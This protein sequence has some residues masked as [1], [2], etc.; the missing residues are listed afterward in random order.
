MESLW[1][2]EAGCGLW[3]GEAATCQRALWREGLSLLA[4][5]KPSRK[6]FAAYRMTDAISTA[7]RA[8]VGAGGGVFGGVIVEKQREPEV[9]AVLM[10][11][12][13]EHFVRPSRVNRRD[14]VH[15]T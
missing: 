3:T 14:T 4:L 15:I 1:T 7:G 5:P 6:L 11:A 12:G 10:M 2:G 13:H 8:R 9:E